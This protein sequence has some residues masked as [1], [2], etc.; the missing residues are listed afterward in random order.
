[1]KEFNKEDA[2]LLAKHRVKQVKGFYTHCLVYIIINS[3]I[4]A[5]KINRNFNN[6]ETFSEAFFDLGTSMTWMLWGV[7][8]GLHAFSVFGLPLILGK[9][10][11]QEK[12]KKYMEEELQNPNKN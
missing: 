8:L 9:N 3:I 1:M 2:Y 5:F 6:G 7:G 10:W 4:T 12:I 11:E